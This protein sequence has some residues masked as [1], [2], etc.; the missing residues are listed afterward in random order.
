MCH[1]SDKYFICFISYLSKQVYVI[2]VIL[3]YPYFANDDTDPEREVDLLKV[4]L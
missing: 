1:L 2:G 4:A 3:Y